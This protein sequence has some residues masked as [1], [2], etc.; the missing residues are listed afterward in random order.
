[1]S[2]HAERLAARDLIAPQG[3]RPQAV[4]L[5]ADKGYDAKDFV[6]ELRELNVRPHVARHSK[7]GARRSPRLPG[8][9]AMP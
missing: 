7:A 9:P 1:M 2:G 4:T 6:M 5:G 3:E 8:I